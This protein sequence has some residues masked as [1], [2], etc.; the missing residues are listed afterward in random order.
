MRWASDERRLAEACGAVLTFMH[1]HPIAAT[2]GRSDLAS[3]DMMSL[4][5]AKRVWQA[6]LDPRRQTPSIGNVATN[7]SN[8][9]LLY[10]EQGRNTKAKPLYI[11]AMEIQ[12]RTLGAEH[13]G[14][15]ASLHNLAGLYHAQGQY[16]EAEPLYQRA[17]E[18]H[19][20][21]LG[22]QHPKVANSLNSLAG[23]YDNKG[24]Y[25]N[26]EL[27]Y[28]RAL[29]INE[30]GLGPEHDGVARGLNNLAE[31]YRAQ[32]QYAKAEPLYGRALAILEKALG[33]EHPNVAT[34]LNSLAVLYET[35]GQYA[36]AEPYLNGRCRFAKRPCV[37]NT[38]TRPSAWKITLTCY[39]RW[40]VR[41]KQR[42]SNLAQRQL[43]P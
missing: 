42:Y 39:E 1:R 33:L 38:R 34:N 15:A 12:T 22:P 11:R 9:A 5:T 40:I 36:K 20:K 25:A 2:W 14:V 29:A 8:L 27:L 17:L 18:I 10:H 24:Q 31:L 32:G 4:E 6:R 30:K 13:P 41:K 28:Q 43:E 26:A 16:A 21:V 35:Q 7:L 23:L 3:S 19:E 37:R